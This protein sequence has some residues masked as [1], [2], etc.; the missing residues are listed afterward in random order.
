MSSHQ[1]NVLN[2]ALAVKYN[3]FIYK[4]DGKARAVEF[5]LQSAH[6]DGRCLFRSLAYGLN[7]AGLDCFNYVSTE[8]PNLN[9]KKMV[10]LLLAGDDTDE[11]TDTDVD[12]EAVAA[13][14]QRREEMLC[15]LYQSLA[16]IEGDHKVVFAQQL[17]TI[18]RW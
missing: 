18:N 11:D 4:E 3:R 16:D 12:E 5:V 10:Q 1:Y 2:V 14:I 17:G 7:A 9:Q 13:D 6:G 8:T 15:S